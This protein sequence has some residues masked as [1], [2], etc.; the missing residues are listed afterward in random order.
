MC[1]TR[2]F[3]VTEL[4]SLVSSTFHLKQVVYLVNTLPETNMFA[5]ENGLLEY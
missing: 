5:P 2:P 1:K 3:R 4:R